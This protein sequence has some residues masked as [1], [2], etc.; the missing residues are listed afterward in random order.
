MIFHSFFLHN[1]EI[2]LI[3]VLL[4]IKNMKQWKSKDFIKLVERNGFYYTHTKGS[5]QKYVHEDGRH[6]CIPINLAAP[7][8]RRLIKENNLV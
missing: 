6:I 3:F 7:I 8:A 4:N 1:S 2:F 5:H